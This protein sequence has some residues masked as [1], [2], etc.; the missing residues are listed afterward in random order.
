MSQVRRARQA[1]ADLRSISEHIA[2]ESGSRAVARNFLTQ[3]DSKIES[4]S[5]QPLMGDLGEDLG[6]GIRTF[7]FKKNYVVIYRPLD[8]GIDVLRVFH[9]ARDYPQ[10]FHD[11]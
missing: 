11:G 3:L 5:R 10:L 1:E 4:Y 8:D 6:E 7:P 9:S 2:R